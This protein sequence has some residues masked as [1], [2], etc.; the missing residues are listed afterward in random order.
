MSSAERLTRDKAEAAKLGVSLM[1]YRLQNALWE[2]LRN[3]GE[4]GDC[5]GDINGIDDHDFY[6]ED[7]V[8][9]VTAVNGEVFAMSCKLHPVQRSP[10]Q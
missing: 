4:S 9:Q 7:H 3:A 6:D 10:P 5:I 1:H 2:W 8:L